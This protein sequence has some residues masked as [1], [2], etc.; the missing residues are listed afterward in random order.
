LRRGVDIVIATPGRLVDLMQQGH[1]NLSRVEIVVLD[2]AD[3]M[4][5]MGFLPDLKRVIA[6][7][8][9]QRQTLLFSATMPPAV[10]QLAN[11]LLTRPARVNVT[12]ANAAP[13]RIDEVVHMLA[14]TQKVST[15][16]R[17]LEAEAV[18]RA[19][20]F[21]RTKHGAN[22]LVKDL[23]R[24]GF[25]A[26]AIHGNKSQAA[27]Q[28]A[29][30]AFKS[31]KP[32]V[33]VATDVAARGID[34]DRITHVINFDLPVEV[35]TYTH[36]IGRTGRA[37][38]AGIAISFC[39]PE[40]HSQLRII[41]RTLKRQLR[42]IRE[43]APAAS[44]A[45]QADST[46]DSHGDRAYAGSA[47]NGRP[48]GKRPRTAGTHPASPASAASGHN[49]SARPARRP[50][51]SRGRHEKRNAHEANRGFERRFQRKPSS[52]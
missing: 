48:H 13:L 16:R 9:T 47:G 25:R 4:L 3:R 1:V 39:T 20:V 10:A 17:L 38:E 22:R 50:F 8:P 12:P 52:T 6:Q 27:R 44:E 19:I 18:K 30:A 43:E 37:G 11:N 45:D 40:E 15:L 51:A 21:T 33:L 7:L 41:Q 36:R 31:A 32:P 26:E 5:D 34:V 29:L 14:K 49:A 42:V 46:S 24:A 2:E 28:R 35:E 23:T